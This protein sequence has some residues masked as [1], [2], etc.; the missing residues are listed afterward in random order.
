MILGSLIGALLWNI[1]QRM[2]VIPY[3]RFGTAYQ[4]GTDWLSR[5]VGKELPPHTA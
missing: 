4:N 1:T 3:R 5:N 2:V